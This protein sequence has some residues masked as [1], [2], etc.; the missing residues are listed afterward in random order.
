MHRR[1]RS[2]DYDSWKYIA[3]I[4]KAASKRKAFEYGTWGGKFR[5]GFEP[6]PGDSVAQEHWCSDGFANTDLLLKEHGIH[7]F[8][9]IG[10][11]ARTCRGDCS[12][13]R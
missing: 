7:K 3:P 11:I 13:H 2:G 8:I 4:Q 6:H 12:V 10:L 1:Y 9:V 5:S